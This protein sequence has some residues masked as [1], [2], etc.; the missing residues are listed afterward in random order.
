MKILT[1][2]FLMMKAKISTLNHKK[3][4][5]PTIKVTIIKKM[6]AHKIL[7]TLKKVN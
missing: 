7:Q 1:M 5:I 4:I 2:I 3:T 6:K